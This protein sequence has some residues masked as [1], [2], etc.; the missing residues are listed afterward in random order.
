MAKKKAKNDNG[1]PS[2]YKAAYAQQAATVCELGASDAKLAKLFGVT[3]STIFEWYSKYP[4]FNEAVRKA[5][6]ALAAGQVE[7][8]LIQQALPHDEVTQYHQLK[9]RGRNRKMTLVATKTVKNKV[10][11]PAA[12][13]VLKS[14]M[15]DKYGDKLGVTHGGQVKYSINITKNYKKNYAGSGSDK[16]RD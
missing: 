4:K 6:A 16:K 10:S 9:G 1:R 2:K 11:V 12:E 7:R 14:A 13:R 5:R 15:P 8:S 3:R